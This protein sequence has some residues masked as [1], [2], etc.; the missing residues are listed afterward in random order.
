MKTL[1]YNR[2]IFHDICSLCIRI[3][4][5]VPY[6]YIQLKKD[7]RSN[8]ILNGGLT[9]AT[10]LIVFE[11]SCVANCLITQQHC[12]SMAVSIAFL[13]YFTSV[14]QMSTKNLN[15]CLSFHK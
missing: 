12:S 5:F 1:T 10:K 4:F 15:N 2:F 9:Y 6:L 8:S 14:S 13:I 3:Q 11:G 7:V